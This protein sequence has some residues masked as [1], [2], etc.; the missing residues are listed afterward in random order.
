MPW[1]RPVFLCKKKNRS[2]HKCRRAPTLVSLVPPSHHSSL[3]PLSVHSL[4]FIS[5]HHSP[6][7]YIS[8]VR[9]LCT[10]QSPSLYHRTPSPHNPSLR[11]TTLLHPS[12]PFTSQAPFYITVP[13]SSF[14]SVSSGPL[15]YHRHPPPL[16]HSPPSYRSPP[17]LTLQSPPPY[18]TDPPSLHSPPHY[19]PQ[20]YSDHRTSLHITAHTPY[21]TVLSL[22]Y[23]PPPPLLL[24]PQSP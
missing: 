3:R 19:T 24:T 14:T 6:P 7:F 5:Q 12:P 10:S 2:L 21:I 22:Y 4:T 16:H 8:V 11:Y 20:F 18:I 13:P 9:L 15:L 1:Q 23:S 17:P